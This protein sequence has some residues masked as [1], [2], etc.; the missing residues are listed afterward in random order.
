V[1]DDLTIGPNDGPHINL[2]VAQPGAVP[3]V[4]VFGSNGHR[5][6]TL[7]AGGPVGQPDPTSAGLN[8]LARDG[9]E[10]AR[11]GTAGT[12]G[13][14]IHLRDRGGQN[15]VLISLDDDGNPSIQL[16]DAGGNVIWSAP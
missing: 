3:Q 16:L 14:E 15:R 8:I 9:S 12:T 5:R 11:V 1:A 13:A 4:N 10:I 2:A 7:A 6:V